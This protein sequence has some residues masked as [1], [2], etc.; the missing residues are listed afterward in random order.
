MFSSAHVGQSHT[1]EL[2]VF[3]HK[4][5]MT[6]KKTLERWFYLRIK[7]NSQGISFI[8]IPQKSQKQSRACSWLN[9][10]KVTEV[11]FSSCSRVS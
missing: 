5:S 8:I 7:Q 3:I 9:K 6:E 2:M 4:G 1:A 11:K 10:K